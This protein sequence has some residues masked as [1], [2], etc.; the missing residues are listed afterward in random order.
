LWWHTAEL[1]AFQELLITEG[2]IPLVWFS[3]T[4]VLLFINLKIYSSIQGKGCNVNSEERD[5][6]SIAHFF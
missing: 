3:S 4:Y 2:A 5:P 6:H 1:P